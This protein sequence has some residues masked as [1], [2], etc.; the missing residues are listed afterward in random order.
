MVSSANSYYYAKSLF[1]Y[2]SLNYLIM[3]SLLELRHLRMLEALV[4]SGNLSRAAQRLH[5]TQS[6]ISH[7]VKQIEDHYGV[8][9]FE[10][11]TQPLRLPD[12]DCR[13]WPERCLRKWQK[14]SAISRAS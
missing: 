7:Q 11:K 6:A 12:S 1:S 4:G 13:F 2:S 3:L 8:P 14:P 10:R 5:L 9:L